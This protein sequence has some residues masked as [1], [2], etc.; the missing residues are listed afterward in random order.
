MRQT[1]HEVRVAS[2]TSVNQLFHFAVRVARESQQRKFC[3]AECTGSQK[4]REEDGWVGVILTASVCCPALSVSAQLSWLSDR[5]RL[6]DGLSQCLLWLAAFGILS[7]QW[8]SVFPIIPS[9]FIYLGSLWKEKLDIHNVVI[10]ITNHKERCS[11]S[12]SVCRSVENVINLNNM[13]KV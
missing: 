7:S 3:R 4:D 13:F 11:K 10:S 12:Q 1:W 8:D 2:I 6:G 5:K 9:T